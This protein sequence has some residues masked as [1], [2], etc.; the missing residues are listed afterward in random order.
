MV[1][2]EPACARRRRNGGCGRN[3]RKESPPLSERVPAGADCV[4][5]PTASRF[6]LRFPDRSGRRRGPVRGRCTAVRPRS[7]VVCNGPCRAWAE[8]RRYAPPRFTFLYTPPRQ[9]CATSSLYV[10]RLL[11][12]P[13][14]ASA[15]FPFRLTPSYARPVREAPGKGVRGSAPRCGRRGSRR[16]CAASRR[17]CS[18]LRPCGLSPPGP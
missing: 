10:P 8:C 4:R 1:Q 9:P 17:R 14:A 15:A 2:R 16:T 18:W 11:K 7:P 3:P 12:L 6:L 13:Y 5:G